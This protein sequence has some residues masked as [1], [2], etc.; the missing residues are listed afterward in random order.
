[1]PALAT[2][3]H[4]PQWVS[5]GPPN[6][7]GGASDWCLLPANHPGITWDH[8]APGGIALCYRDTTDLHIYAVRYAREAWA[9]YGRYLAALHPELA[10]NW[11][12]RVLTNASEKKMEWERGEAHYTRSAQRAPGGWYLVNVSDVKHPRIH[13]LAEDY[14]LVE[15]TQFAQKYATHR[16]GTDQL[17]RN[18]MVAGQPEWMPPLPVLKESDVRNANKYTRRAITTAADRAAGEKIIKR[19]V[20]AGAA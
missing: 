13:L 4:A 19:P 3:K 7:D 16:N 10:R 8:V 1:M 11:T 18:S 14:A 17:R 15:W 5:H 20:V 9:A 12:P 2:I 6:T